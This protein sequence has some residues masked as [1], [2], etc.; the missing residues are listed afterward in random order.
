MSENTQGG[1]VS[2]IAFFSFILILVYPHFKGSG[3]MKNR[4]IGCCVV[5]CIIFFYIL[6]MLF[7]GNQKEE[8]EIEEQFCNC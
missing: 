6:Y 8:S 7:G 4:F 3:V 5:F 2:K 1:I